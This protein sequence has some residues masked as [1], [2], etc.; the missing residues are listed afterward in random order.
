M[1]VYSLTLTS[2]PSIAFNTIML[3]FVS[4]HKKGQAGKKAA[5]EQRKK[6]KAAA[7]EAAGESKV[8]NC[9]KYWTGLAEKLKLKQRTVWYGIQAVVLFLSHKGAVLH[10]HSEHQQLQND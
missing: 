4:A 10:S 3:S 7:K 1:F 5:S 8:R 9:N 2:C 6:E